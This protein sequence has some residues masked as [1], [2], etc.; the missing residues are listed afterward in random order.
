MADAAEVDFIGILWQLDDLDNRQRII[1]AT[2]F[3]QDTQTVMDLL[4]FKNQ[5]T[6][7]LGGKL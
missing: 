2:P 7:A 1:W 5:V 3:A 6:L 4:T